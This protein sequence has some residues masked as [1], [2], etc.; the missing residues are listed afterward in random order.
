MSTEPWRIVGAFVRNLVIHWLVM[1]S[2][3][4]AL[5]AALLLAQRHLYA[6]ILIVAVIG[7]LLMG[8][9]LARELSARRCI[10][11]PARQP[12]DPCP[13]A[14]QLLQA[15]HLILFAGLAMCG[16]SAALGFVASTRMGFPD[17][18]PLSIFST[19]LAPLSTW[20]D[21]LIPVLP[22]AQPVLPP[23]SQPRFNPE[24]GR[25]HV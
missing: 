8:G 15:P 25:A 16:L 11:N 6:V 3:V 18:I 23:D 10:N 19:G 22:L 7:L 1:V 17:W 24:I 13:M 21:S 20:L 5:F 12:A 9:G 14:Q 4:F 2:A